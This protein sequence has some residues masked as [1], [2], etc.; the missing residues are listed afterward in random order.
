MH[1]CPWHACDIAGTHRRAGELAESTVR[2][3]ALGTYSCCVE[4]DPLCPC[5]CSCPCSRSYL[6]G[7]ASCNHCMDVV[8]IA[9][10][11]C[12]RTLVIL[13]FPHAEEHS[14]FRNYACVFATTAPQTKHDITH[15]HVAEHWRACTVRVWF[16]G[17]TRHSARPWTKCHRRVDRHRK[18][19]TGAGSA[20]VSCE[21]CKVCRLAQRSRC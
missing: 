6:S 11:A 19:L 18:S 2:A 20:A 7:I 4:R 12:L 21:E 16:S 15:V 10:H 5:H 1:A 9:R 8:A 14:S 13:C 3:C 17:G